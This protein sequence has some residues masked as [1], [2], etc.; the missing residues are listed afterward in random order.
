KTNFLSQ[1]GEITG[2]SAQPDAGLINLIDTYVKFVEAIPLSRPAVGGKLTSGYGFRYSPFNRHLSL[3]EGI[4][5]SL[6]YGSNIYS[7]AKGKVIRLE[8]NSTYGLMIDVEHSDKVITR[9]AHLSKAL[10]AEGGG[11]EPGQ[12]IGL[13]GSSGRSTGPHLHYEVRVDGR[14]K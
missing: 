8:R 7:T 2:I 10:V 12:L 9:Y 5:L 11:V 13:A 1:N 6:S 3:H 4:D 14:A